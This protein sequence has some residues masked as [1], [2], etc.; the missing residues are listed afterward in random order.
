MSLPIIVADFS[1]ASPIETNTTVKGQL[2]AIQK[3]WAPVRN[4]ILTK[5]ALIRCL[6]FAISILQ[7][8]KRRS[9]PCI[10]GQPDIVDVAPKAGSTSSRPKSAEPAT[11][12]KELSV[13][14]APVMIKRL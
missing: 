5:S 12:R 1:T 6:K 3:D 14:V 4:V 10:R 2:T 7:H 8:I 11:W 9:A 13:A